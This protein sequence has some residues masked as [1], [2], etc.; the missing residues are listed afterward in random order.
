MSFKSEFRRPKGERKPK[1]I[2]QERGDNQIRTLGCRAL[3]FVLAAALAFLAPSVHAQNLSATMTT[4]LVATQGQTL[5]YTVVITNHTASALAGVTFGAVLDQNTTLVPNSINTSPLALPD[6]YA[7]LGNV[8]I[9]N[10]APGVRAN[11]MDPD[12]VGPVLTVTAGSFTSANDGD[13]VLSANGAFSYNPPPGFEGADTFTYA[14]NDGEGF[15]DTGTVTVNVS[16][17][18][19]F[20]NSGGPAGDG[21][22]TNPF[23]S[24]AALAT[25][26]N[27]NGNNPAAGDIIFLYS[28][29]H[30]GPINLLNNQRLIGQGTTALL[31]A[32]TGLI[33]PAG[34]LALPATGGTRP[35]ITGNGGGISLASGNRVRGLN[36]SHNGGT[37]LAGGSVG[38]LTV[39]EAAIS[40]T[41]G[42]AV[43][44]TG[45][46]LDV[47][48]DNVSASGGANGIALAN[49]TG[50]FSVTGNGALAQN[51]TGGTI[52]NTTGNGVQ[53]NNVENVSLA[54]MNI[55]NCLGSGI[56]GRNVNG[57]IIDWCSL[58]NN[59]DAVAESGI[60]LGDPAA[61]MNGL[62]GTL[63]DGANPT[64]IANTLIRASSEM[65]VA[66]FNNGGTLSQLEVTNVVSKDTRTRPLGA[67]GFFFE[68]RGNGQA[69]VNFTSCSLS[70]N[71][72][73]GIQVSALAQSVLNVSVANCGFTN[74]N[75]GIRRAGEHHDPLCWGEEIPRRWDE[76]R[77]SWERFSWGGPGF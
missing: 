4:A 51:G 56:S 3:V 20:V 76:A 62:I 17:M 19:W 13:V 50:R 41:A 71:F 9:T 72:T 40:N 60:R 5:T 69:T 55:N 39:A 7:A 49:T 75:E 2:I 47:T 36:L 28:G 31:P 66:I 52:Q 24:L 46:T 23:N 45:G 27:G 11:D 54:R 44:L 59:G 1:L 77:R 10:A 38:A 64:R 74:N 65:N 25:L 29:N 15:T 61:F 48:L 43:N 14:L 57:F 67:D 18:I 33:P 16:G 37:A 30:A 26:N 32:L 68:V 70:N 6:T 12:G 35:N 8:R 21:R 73:Q 58:S 42:I 34:S 22:L 63:P 53:L